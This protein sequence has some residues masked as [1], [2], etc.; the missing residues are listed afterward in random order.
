MLGKGL[1]QAVPTLVA[2]IPQICQALFDVFTAFRWMDIGK[3]IV[4][5]LWKGL[6]G[7]WTALTKKVGDLVQQLPDIAKRV[8]GIHSPS[9]VFDEIGVNT[10]K[11]LAQGLHKGTQKVKDAAKTVVAS[12]TSSAT[13]LED[14]VTTATEIV[15]E[16]MASGATQQKKTVTETSRQMV[17]GVLS[18][19]KTITTT[20]ADGSQK[21]TQSIEAVRDVISAVKS[22]QT[23]LVDG[24]ETT[25]EKTVE[26]LADGTEQI[27]TVT[28]QTGKEV[29]DGVEHTV[30]T[31]TTTA[32]DGTQTVEKI[33]EDARNVVSTVKDTQTSLVDGVETT[34]ERTTETLADGTEQQKQ[35]IT[36]TGTEIIDGIKRTVKTVTTIAADGTKTVAKTIEDAGP[37][38][39][40]AAELLT[41]Q[42]RAKIEDGWQQIESDIQTDAL[43]AIETL[44]KAIQS[45]DLEQLGLWAA[46]YF[47]NACTDAQKQQI[48]DLAL[49]A[50]NQLSS[51]LSGVGTNLA[52]LASSLVAK[53]VPAATTATGAQTALNVAMDAN[54]IMLV[55]SLI[56]MLVGALVNF[57]ST[58]KEVA[59]SVKN[60]WNG[61][62]DFMS[63][64]FEGALRVVGL[65]IEGFILTINSLISAYNAIPGVE[66]IDKV[67]N[68][69]WNGAD[70]LA[71]DR[72]QRQEER[73]AQGK[74]DAQYAADTSAA[75]KKQM[76]AQYAKKKAEL[77]K[78]KLSSDDPGMLDAEK[79]LAKADYEK[80]LADLKKKLIDA[81]YEK[82]S[83]ELAKKSTKDIAF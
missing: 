19:V 27:K 41:S 23:S 73:S 48:N 59:A 50:L 15:T 5:G 28:T 63:I 3:Q 12:V 8:L 18:D 42:F 80:D 56:G 79:A 64:I 30:K 82:A 69:L 10:C 22:T 66:K 26:T 13:Q 16:R 39:A 20:A 62:A 36:S 52:A 61:L 33:I 45:G 1:L 6:T 24:I 35:V 60:V 51:A 46:E 57:A 68:P 21:V 47:W 4:D 76:E 67:K 65:A 9:K 53:F 74:L 72:K 37:Q 55:I 29:I 7:G 2:N 38:Y 43:G 58:N 34:V 71:A 83:A 54:P 11:G 77:E 31:V 25:V 40:S 78:A 81:E 70:K 32:A 75:E 17:N 44:A 49:G 14:G